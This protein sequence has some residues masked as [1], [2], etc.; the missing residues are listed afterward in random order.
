MLEL[1]FVD[2]AVVEFRHYY[3]TCLIDVGE[4]TKYI[5]AEV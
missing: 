3:A 2:M 5:L 4:V 1:K